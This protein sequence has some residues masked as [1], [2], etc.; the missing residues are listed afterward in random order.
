MQEKGKTLQKGRRSTK[1]NLSFSNEMEEENGSSDD[2][3]D[4]CDDFQNIQRADRD[5]LLAIDARI[6]ELERAIAN[7]KLPAK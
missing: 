5:S 6:D 7:Y 4:D 2:D 1:K 3:F